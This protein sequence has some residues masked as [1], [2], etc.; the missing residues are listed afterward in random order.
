MR[1]SSEPV[2]CNKNTLVK[3]RST[4]TDSSYKIVTSAKS[5]KTR[6]QFS[7][8]WHGFLVDSSWQS[9]WNTTW[10]QKLGSNRYATLQGLL[11]Q[12][13][14]RRL[15]QSDWVQK[16]VFLGLS[17]PLRLHE[18]TF[19]HLSNRSHTCCY[20]CVRR[21]IMSV[22]KCVCKLLSYLNSPRSPI[23]E[24]KLVLSKTRHSHPWDTTLAVR[25]DPPEDRRAFSPK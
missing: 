8:C 10:G 4:R 2:V 18:M 11:F 19:Y 7:R 25:Q 1:P 5:S 14:P 9:L 6:V 21:E 20:L 15:S 22:N 23:S 12:S 3:C 13:L 17:F 24:K 16:V